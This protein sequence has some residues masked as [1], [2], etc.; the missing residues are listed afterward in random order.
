MSVFQMI[1]HLLRALATEIH[2]SVEKIVDRHVD[3]MR[4][5]SIATILYL[6]AYYLGIE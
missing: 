1:F 2:R 5:S 4:K 3:K 6:I